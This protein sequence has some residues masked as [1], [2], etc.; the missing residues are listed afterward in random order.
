MIDTNNNQLN[1]RNMLLSEKINNMNKQ[2]DQ[3]SIYA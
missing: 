3:A 2:I 1:R